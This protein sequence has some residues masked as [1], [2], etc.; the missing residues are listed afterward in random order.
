MSAHDR[1]PLNSAA[2]MNPKP[3]L[4][5]EFYGSSGLAEGIKGD[6]APDIT[7]TVA[8][9]AAVTAK[10]HLT[11]WWGRNGD[12]FCEIWDSLSADARKRVIFETGPFTPK[13]RSDC[14]VCG[15]CCAQKSRFCVACESPTFV[16]ACAISPMDSAATRL[17]TARKAPTAEA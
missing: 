15:E 3:N 17:Q 6:K 13:S 1:V 5:I 7:H 12:K 9:E 10:L 8:R 2:T 11:D 4:D 16:R 14:R